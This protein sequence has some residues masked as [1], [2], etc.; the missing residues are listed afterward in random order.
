MWKNNTEIAKEMHLSRQAV[1]KILKK[2]LTKVYKN[3]MNN[4]LAESPWDALLTMAT[5]FGIRDNTQESDVKDFYDL[6]P[7]YIK[8]EVK[9][10]L[11]NN[12][13][14]GM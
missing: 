3:I 11:K 8:E 10:D 13:F 4:D 12:Y 9:L 5:M 14:I 7:D 2:S 1:S 6:L